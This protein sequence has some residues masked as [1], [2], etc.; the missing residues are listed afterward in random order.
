MHSVFS[1]NYVVL[2]ILPLTPIIFKG[3][4]MTN[5]ANIKKL[6]SSTVLITKLDESSVADLY[7]LFSTYYEN[8]SEKQF[9]I[10]LKNKKKIIL[11]RNQENKICG[12]S[13]LTFFEL[14]KYPG[15]PFCIYSGDTIIDK[16]YWGTSA[17]TIEFLKNILL[18]KM[19]RPFQPVWWFLIS[20]G[21]KTYL[22]LANNFHEYYPR[23]DVETPKEKLDLIECLVNKIYP[24]NFCRETGI[25]SFK[26]ETHDRLRELVAPITE[27]MCLRNKKIKFFRD[28]NLNWQQGDELACIGKI[29]FSL[30]I[31]HPSKVL[32]KIAKKSFIFSPSKDFNKTL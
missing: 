8:T 20:K 18:E 27:Q 24:N 17:L 16:D 1:V 15:K 26:D 10:D 4:I 6:K 11:L 3:K 14:D 13:T 31:T 7:Q 5:S 23:V 28:S 12:F 9:R 21:Y 29:S 32:K 22:L 2:L 19:K 30:G 25:I